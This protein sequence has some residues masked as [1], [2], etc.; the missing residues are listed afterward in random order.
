MTPEAGSEE[1]GM[2]NGG[3]APPPASGAMQDPASAATG[4]TPNVGNKIL[5]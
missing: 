5:R 1:P 4:M 2:M 3:V